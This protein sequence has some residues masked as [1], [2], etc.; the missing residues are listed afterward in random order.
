MT[1]PRQGGGPPDDPAPFGLEVAERLGLWSLRWQ[2]A[3]DNAAKSLAARYQALA[4][5]LGRMTAVEE[6]RP[7]RESVKPAGWPVDSKPSRAFAEITRFFRP[8]DERGVDRVIPDLGEFERPLN[9]RGIAVTPAERVEIAGRV[10]RAI[11]DDAIDRFLASPR[12]DGKHPDEGAI[13][14][15]RLAERLGDWSDFWRQAQD[16]AD[17]DSRLAA[18]RNGPTRLASAR[19]RPAEPDLRPAT[20]RSHIE[21]MSALESGRSL[22]DALKGTG[23]PALEPV[24]MNRL[25]EFVEV[26]RF[27]RIEAESQLPTVSKPKG[28]DA[29]ASSQ[30][31]ARIYRA[32]LDDAIRR[33][34]ELPREGGAPPDASLV[35]DPRLAERLGAWS[36][37]WARAQ[38]GEG[39][40]TLSRFAAVRSHMERMASLEDGRTLRNALAPADPPLSKSVVPASPREFA[41]VARFFRLEAVW[42][43][44][45]IR[46]R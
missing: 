39:E 42:E 12:V 4:D 27:F 2:E 31:A 14:D 37:H 33:C 21:R 9:P 40:G 25:R 17:K 18:A 11:L 36:I 22:E 20:V 8:V 41:E 46:S 5:H 13:F 3:Q 23:R 32:I 38:A 29:T 26:A 35:F 28:G 15:A 6:G 7:L 10:Y 45:R 43:L 1:P 34:R 44:E 19:A 30:A 24:D 16:A